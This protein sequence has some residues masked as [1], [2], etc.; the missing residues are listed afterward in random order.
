MSVKKLRLSALC[1]PLLALSAC[2]EGWEP[3]KTDTVFP[4]GNQRTAGYG[5]VYV[6]AKMMPEKELVV[7]PMVEEPA[8]AEEPAAEPEVTPLKPADEI[9][10]EAQT[11]GGHPVK[12]EA[13]VE[14]EP[15]AEEVKDT[16]MDK[17][18]SAAPVAEVEEVAASAPV[19]TS[20]EDY[21]SQ[22]PKQIEIPEVKII[23][24]PDEV[25]IQAEEPAAEAGVVEAASGGIAP[26][27]PANA[28]YETHNKRMTEE[29]G[30]QEAVVENHNE[31][32][33][34]KAEEVIAPKRD[35]IEGSTTG[36]DSLREIYSEPF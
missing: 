29:L 5:V 22:A 26:P 8:V 19:T 6:R 32:A 1:L 2:G 7:E 13:A 12:R 10:H 14:A 27:P 25:A 16:S 31:A 30:V 36:H 35:Y 33:Q 15:A 3:Q 34:T 28:A 11:K 21:I 23:D 24:E 17:E 20:A 4:Y 18:A 9:F